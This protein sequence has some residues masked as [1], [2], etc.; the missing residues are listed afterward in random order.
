MSKPNIKVQ[1]RFQNMEV[2]EKKNVAKRTNFL[3]TINTNQSYK[4]NDPNL[5][6]DIEFFDTTIAS[7][8]NNLD[9]YIK[10][11][12]GDV[13]NDD[14][15]KD[16]SAD[17][18]IEKGLQKNNL[19]THIFISVTH[20]TDVKLDYAKIKNKIKGDLGL[21]NIYMLN[22]VVKNAGN[23]SIIEYLEKYT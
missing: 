4:N 12:A 10:L 13:W 19:H 21:N 18:V 5:Q 20:F 3:L 8:L 7:V 15:I 16:V 22:K 11:P 17:Y 1:G 14:L 23:L 6:N 2:K 9:Q